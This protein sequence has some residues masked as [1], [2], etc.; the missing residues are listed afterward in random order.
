MPMRGDPEG[1]P[2]A[3]V[4]RMSNT[5]RMPLCV[6]I[7]AVSTPLGESVRWSGSCPSAVRGIPDERTY[8]HLIA[9][10]LQCVVP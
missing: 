3:C 1:K 7:A 8:G 10:P 9:F 4:E 6:V 2:A 5:R